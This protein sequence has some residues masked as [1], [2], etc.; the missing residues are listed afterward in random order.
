MHHALRDRAGRQSCG[1]LIR[2][3]WQTLSKKLCNVCMYHICTYNNVCVRA[4]MRHSTTEKCVRECVRA[5]VHACVRACVH[6][7]TAFRLKFATHW[8]NNIA[9]VCICM[10]ACEKACVYHM[11]V[12]NNVCMRVYLHAPCLTLPYLTLPYLTNSAVFFTN[13]CVD[14][15]IKL[16]SSQ[17]PYNRVCSLQFCCFPYNIITILLFSLQFCCFPYRS[18]MRTLTTVQ[19]C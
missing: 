15:T 8:N 7:F 18:N 17:I 10:R 3:S 13:Y 6:A 14:L 9:C 1:C 2:R 4:C 11:C 19:R 12:Y 5:C 16:F